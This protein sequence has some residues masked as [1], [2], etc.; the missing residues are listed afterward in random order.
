MMTIDFASVCCFC[1]EAGTHESTFRRLHRAG[2]I[3][4]HRTPA[5]LATPA[6]A[7][8]IEQIEYLPREIAAILAILTARGLAVSDET[9]ARI[10]ACKEA[11]S[12]DRWIVCAATAASAE[13]L[14][15][16]HG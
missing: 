7:R 1:A 16:E 5:G 4:E 13:A 9:R 14:F 6:D 10:E 12:L 3:D 15:S 11:A 8:S 2:R